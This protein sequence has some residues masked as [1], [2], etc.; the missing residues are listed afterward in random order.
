MEPNDENPLE[1]SS[2]LTGALTAMAM[3]VLF[4][5]LISV[6]GYFVYYK[7]KEIKDGIAQEKMIKE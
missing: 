7:V 1:T 6:A 5:L 3:G 2:P 4:A